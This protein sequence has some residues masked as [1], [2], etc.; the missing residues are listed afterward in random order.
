MDSAPVPNTQPAPAPA[1]ADAVVPADGATVG[2]EE[3]RLLA[4]LA[5]AMV[6]R[7]RATLQELAHAV[8]VSKATLYRF[9]RTREQLVERLLNH[10]VARVT[11][12][13]DAA[14]LDQGTPLEALHRLIVHMLEQRKCGAFL[15]MHY[16]QDGATGMGS[17]N[18][19]EAQLDAFFLRGQQAGA[20]RIDI[21]TPALTE[22][23]SSIFS[24]LV[25][26]ERRGRIARTSLAG[27]FEQAFLQGCAA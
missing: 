8:G 13:M 17:E 20:L 23:W 10:S 24:G 25:E 6:E 11:A 22:L 7:P 5:Q 2:E 9:C 1:A 27:L 14:R 12:A 16:W 19:W 3:N 4:A 21:A 26:A 15:M 18:G